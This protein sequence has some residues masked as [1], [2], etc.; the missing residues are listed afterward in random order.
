MTAEAWIILL[1][2][3]QLVGGLLGFFVLGPLFTRWLS[4]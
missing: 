2:I 1:P 3:S 4:K